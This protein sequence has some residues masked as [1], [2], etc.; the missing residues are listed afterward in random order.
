MADSRLCKLSFQLILV[1]PSHST[2]IALSFFE[3]LEKTAL[4]MCTSSILVTWSALQDGLY[5]GQA[6]SLEDFFVS[7]RGLA[8]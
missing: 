4:G 8:I 3:L 6:D 7:T 2:T 1:T 5:A